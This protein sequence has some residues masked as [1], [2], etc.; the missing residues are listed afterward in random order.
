[1]IDADELEA[2]RRDPKIKKLLADAAA[3]CRKGGT[4]VWP[5][6]PGRDG[7]ACVKCGREPL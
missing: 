6:D 3:V 1:M 2:A 4:H 7:T 5:E